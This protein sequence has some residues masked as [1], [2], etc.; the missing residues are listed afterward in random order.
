M[1]HNDIN[2]DKI[3]D[4]I[5]VSMER[6]AFKEEIPFIFFEEL[7][8]RVS[9]VLKTAIGTREL[10]EAIGALK[11]EGK[12]KFMVVARREIYYLVDMIKIYNNFLSK[13]NI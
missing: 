2:P 10:R 8:T 11:K 4:A 12:I 7:R 3:Y 9:G 1:S 5:I 6:K 13:K